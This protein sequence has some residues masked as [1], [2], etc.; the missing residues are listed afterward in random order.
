MARFLR[1]ALRRLGG[2][3][4]GPE[5][6][7]ATRELVTADAPVIF[8]VGANVGATARRYRGLYPRAEIHCFEP[9]APSFARLSTALSGD[10]LISLHP[11]ALSSAAGRGVLNVNRNAETN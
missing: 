10:R 5:P 6:H 1:A 2:R 4:Q 11:T 9:Y 7:L 3:R 8:D